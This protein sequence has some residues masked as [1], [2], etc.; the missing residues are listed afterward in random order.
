MI[1]GIGDAVAAEVPEK[2]FETYSEQKYNGVT[3]VLSKFFREKSDE[4]KNAVGL[5]NHEKI[6]DAKYGDLRK[7]YE[8]GKDKTN[9]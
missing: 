1:F 5:Y 3:T 8:E 2:K 9:F 6:K 4:N 7:I